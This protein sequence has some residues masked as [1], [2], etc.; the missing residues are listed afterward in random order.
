MTLHRVSVSFS[1]ESAT[2]QMLF[3]LD[4]R[5]DSISERAVRHWHCCP[6]SGVTFPGGVTDYG[7]VALRDV[8]TGHGGMG[9]DLGVWR[10]FPT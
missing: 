1:W 5:N 6:G 9:L 2:A 7:G 10:S 3:R 4:I 8:A